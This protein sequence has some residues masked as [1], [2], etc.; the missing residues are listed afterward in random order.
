MTR[1]LRGYQR[2]AAQTGRGFLAALHSRDFSRLVAYH[3]AIFG[4]VLHFKGPR[5]THS[6]AKI[7]MQRKEV[8][9]R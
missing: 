6:G 4:I 5:S 1:R 3:P 8:K 2:I 7:P 9:L